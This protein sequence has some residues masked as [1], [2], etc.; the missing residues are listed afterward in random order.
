[1]T[2]RKWTITTYVNGQQ[3][4]V[5]LVVYDTLGM[6]RREATRWAKRV[7]PFYV[8][9]TEAVGVCHGFERIRVYADDTEKKHPHAATVRLARGH[10]SILI[11]SHE[12]AHA[13]QHLY[14]L[15]FLGVESKELAVDHF[16]A[17]NEDFAHLYGELFAAAWSAINSEPSQ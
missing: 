10:T 1:M 5:S 15:D 17:A 9:F 2:R 14:S 16:D 13:A 4:E 11:V 7:T 6:M 12:I 8:D 3:R